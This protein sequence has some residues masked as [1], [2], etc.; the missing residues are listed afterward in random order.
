MEQHKADTVHRREGKLTGYDCPKCRNKG[1]IA[2]VIDGEAHLVDCECAAIRKSL[3]M[4]EKSGLKSVLDRY[5]FDRYQTPEAWQ[6]EAKRQAENYARNPKGWFVALGKV[7]AGK[8]HLC[9]AICGEILKRGVGVKYMLW[10]DEVV[11]LKAVV[12]DDNE[13]DRLI[14]PLKTISC[15]YIDD[16][17][18]GKITEADINIAFEIINSRYNDEDKLTIISSEKDID[19]LLDIDEAIGSRIYERSKGNYIR[20]RGDKNWRML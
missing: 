12:N 19:D 10:R 13:Y 7:G 16:L 20:V 9:T 8:T 15:L 1:Y 5:T 11:K 2:K 6:R 14:Y 4:I 17:F 18:K 3:R